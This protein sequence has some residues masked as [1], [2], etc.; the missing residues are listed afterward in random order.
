P[1]EDVGDASR[2]ERTG[3]PAGVVLLAC[4]REDR[5]RS[6]SWS[7]GF[8]SAAYKKRSQGCH[9]SS[10]GV[11][12]DIAGTVG[13]T[14]GRAAR[15]EGLDQLLTRSNGAGDSYLAAGAGRN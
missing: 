15:A 13:G 3:D 14:V 5:G 1:R 12:C 4:R 9:R 2:V 8:C 7:G 11:A 10:D 6:G